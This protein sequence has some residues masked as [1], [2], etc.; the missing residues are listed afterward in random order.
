VTQLGVA[1]RRVAIVGTRGM[2]AAEHGEGARKATT[3]DGRTLEDM[4]EQRST[5]ELIL[6]S[7]SAAVAPTWDGIHRI[8][9]V[10]VDTS[11]LVADL[12]RATRH[13][14]ETDF[15]QAIEHG[16]LRAFAPHHVW[17]EMG[18]KCRDV[19][20][21]RGLDPHEAGDI[22]WGEYVPRLHFVDT[23]GL[24]V[25]LAEAI[26]SRDPSDAGTFA[27]AGL[28]APVVVL[29][30][31]RDLIDPGLAAQ[32]YQVLVEDA[33]VI[34]VVSQG[35][36]GSLVVTAIAVEGIKGVG[37]GVVRAAQHP[38][39]LPILVALLVV[40][41]ATR[42]SW[43]PR[44]RK[45]APRLWA[46]LRSLAEDAAPGIE[47]LARQYRSA[48]AAWDSAAFD[49]HPSSQRQVVARLLAARPAPMSRSAIAGALEPDATTRR[50]RTLMAE[51]AVL[52]GETAAFTRVGASHWALGRRG[53]DFGGVVGH[54]QRL[55]YPGVP[56]LLLEPGSRTTRP[57]LPRTDD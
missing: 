38:V 29:S 18:R 11:F 10:V 13:G 23:A 33:G 45:G 20:A 40:V 52:L 41:V 49:W 51:L 31:D 2:A 6:P 7:T 55:L 56:R 5:L 48:T 43:L 21:E 35:A 39:G 3:D 4:P 34:T 50:Q 26:L 53:V 54:E 32:S 15:V 27:L 47:E 19:P 9:P 28:L 30:T 24:A 57:G 17:A 12:L 14:R 36:W 16:S 25:P 44:L 8:R 22:W 37:R 1:L 46:D 42:D